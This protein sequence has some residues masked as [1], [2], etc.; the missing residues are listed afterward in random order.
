M[1]KSSRAIRLLSKWVA[2]ERRPRAGEDHGARVALIVAVAGPAAAAAEAALVEAPAADV[3]L[4]VVR[5]AA[6]RGGNN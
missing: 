3:A 6:G 4:G 2:L 5:I 1:A